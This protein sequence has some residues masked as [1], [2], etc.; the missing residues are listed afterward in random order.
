[1]NKSI[2]VFCCLVLSGCSTLKPAGTGALIGITGGPVAINYIAEEKPINRVTYHL[3][4]TG[5]IV[6]TAGICAFNPV[7]CGMWFG[8][9]ALVGA[10]QFSGLSQ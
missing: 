9:N 8:F 10:F 4:I 5:H 2:A 3:A 6:A 7:Y 1:M